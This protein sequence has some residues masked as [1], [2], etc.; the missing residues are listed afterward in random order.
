MSRVFAV[1][2]YYGMIVT[3]GTVAVPL[4]NPTAN[5]V[6]RALTTSFGSI[7]LGSLFLGFMDLVRAFVQSLVHPNVDT[8]QM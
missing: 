4:S 5:A 3:G 1:Y 6:K 7:C 8:K 2:Y